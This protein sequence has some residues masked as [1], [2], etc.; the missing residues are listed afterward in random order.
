MSLKRTKSVVLTGYSGAP[1]M[2]ETRMTE[3]RPL[4]G[5]IEVQVH[6][7]GINFADIYQ[8]SGFLSL[9]LPFTMGLECC[10]IVTAIGYRS[11]KFRVGDKVIC[12]NYM[13]GMYSEQVRVDEI[14]CFKIPRDISFEEGACL[15]INYVS[16][17]LCLLEIG[18]LT[19]G[20]SVFIHSLAGGFGLAAV[21]ICQRFKDVTIYGTASPSKFQYLHDRYGLSNVMVTEDLIDGFCAMCPGGLD[22]VLETESGDVKDFLMSQL[23]PLGRMIILGAKSSIARE[24]IDRPVGLINPVDLILT[25]RIVSGFHLGVLCDNRKELLEEVLQTVIDWLRDGIINPV[26]HSIWD[27]LESYLDAIAVLERRSNIGKILLKIT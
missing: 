6:T 13:G 19:D 17:Y 2:V 8:R 5:L 15:F 27:S 22:I 10:G 24:A 18:N 16:A 4:D 26:I 9:P 20:K 7:C 25:N 14:N 21:Q 3:M 23:R 1:E 11:D 12:Y